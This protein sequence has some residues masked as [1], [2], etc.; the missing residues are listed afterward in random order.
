[1]FENR[2][3]ILDGD[4]VISDTIHESSWSDVRSLRRIYFKKTDLWYLADRWDSLSSA[5]KGELNA[6][7]QTIRDLP[8]DHNNAT[9]AM[10]NFPTPE[11]WF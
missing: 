10:H 4:E 7:R 6:F 5:K 8:Q 2:V 11:E 1:M 3:L 9:E